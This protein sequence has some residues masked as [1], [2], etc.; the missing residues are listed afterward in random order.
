MQEDSFLFWLIIQVSNLQ[1]S[2]LPE[3]DTGES[4]IFDSVGHISIQDG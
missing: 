1:T 2:G 4:N 3:A